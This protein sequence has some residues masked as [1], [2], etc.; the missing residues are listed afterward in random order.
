M[1][2]LRKNIPQKNN[3][4]PAAELNVI[5]RARMMTK[6]ELVIFL[7]PLLKSVGFKKTRTTW[8][9]NSSDGVCVFNIQASQYGPEYYLNVGFYIS[10]LGNLEKP[11]EY[12]CHIRERL[13][14]TSNAEILAQEIQ[15]WFYEFGSINKLRDHAVSETLPLTTY[16]IAREYLVQQ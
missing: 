1:V 3:L 13:N 11:P 16:K 15:N 10:A 4:Q 7:S 2:L 9:R 12:K 8:H 14:I 5:A 6:E